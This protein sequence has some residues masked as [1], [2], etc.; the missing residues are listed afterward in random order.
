MR[1]HARYPAL[2]FFLGITNINKRPGRSQDHHVPLEST[3]VVQ[4]GPYGV[5]LINSTDSNTRMNRFSIWTAHILSCAGAAILIWQV[6]NI[7]H[8]AVVSWAFWTDVYPILCVALGVIHHVLAV[9]CM[10]LGLRSNSPSR[11]RRWSMLWI[12]DLTQSDLRIS[13]ANR[14]WARWSKAANNLFNNWNHLLGTAVFSSLTLVAGH[15]AIQKL[16]TLGVIAFLS[17]GVTEWMLEGMQETTRPQVSD[18]ASYEGAR[19]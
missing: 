1:I 17:K 6:H 8:N 5:L 7:G 10:R 3:E 19:F 11:P 4:L 15:I 12:W 9:T 16:A 18:L 2:A 13:V 14:K